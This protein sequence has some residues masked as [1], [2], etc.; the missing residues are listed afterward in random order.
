MCAKLILLYQIRVLED[1]GPQQVV[2]IHNS[3]PIDGS[4][5]PRKGTEKER[6]GCKHKN[7]SME[8]SREQVGHWK[9]FPFLLH[10]CMF[11]L[12]MINS[13]KNILRLD[14]AAGGLRTGGT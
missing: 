9:I 2:A 7:G 12:W 8:S 14:S 1:S 4:S 10:G 6:N 13:H 3:Q 11:A 5:P